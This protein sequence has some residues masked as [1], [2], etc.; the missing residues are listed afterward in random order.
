MATNY[1]GSLDTSTQQPSPSASTEMD[2][3]GFE[4]DVV[5]ANHSGAIIALETKVGTGD[6]NA[7]A[8]SVLAGTGSGTSAWTTAPTL[9]GLTVDTDTLHVD[10]TNNRVGIG[11]TTPAEPLHIVTAS[12]DAY[13]RQENGTATTYLGPDSANTG[14]FGTSTAHDVRFI[15][16]NT[17]RVRIDSSGNVGIGESSPETPLHIVTANRLGSTF[18]GTVD[19]E[20]L[21]VDQ[22][23]YSSGNYVSLVEASYD[24][25]QTVPHVRI[26]AMF[27]GG[28]SHLAFGTSNS[29]GSGIT[30]TA[31]FI[32][33]D[34]DVG[35]NTTSPGQRFHVNSGN[36]N[37]TSVFESGD[38][39][40]Y[41]GIKDSASSSNI[42]VAVGAVG[43]DMRLRAGNINRVAII[44]SN[45]RVGINTTSPSTTLDVNGSLSKASGSFKIPHP[46]P[47]KADTHDLV[48]SFVEA[49][50][51]DNLYRGRV[52]LTSGAATVDL[53]AAANMT[54]GTFPLLN[55]DVQCFIV[56]ADG[57]TFV[58]GSVSGSTLSIEAQDASCTDTVDWLVIGERHDQHMFD[59]EWTDDEGRVIV[60]PL[61][62]PAPEPDPEPDPEPEPEAA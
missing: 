30:N 56:N 37:T 47:A 19:G 46:L 22:S 32:A 33:E 53:D 39:T 43:N 25:G 61:R 51:A 12:D 58:R 42:H 48:H 10:A 9:S 34:G 16:G 8:S 29:F 2:D 27:D 6:S 17:E 50:Q 57:W 18:T 60:E 14:L 20:G 62:P 24:D 40:A 36:T 15:T 35:I 59:T 5:H 23:D 7:V 3:S 26:G 21:R 13:L 54:T 52:A 41:I 31:L 1:P 4:H 55:R 28:G 11:T 49:P 38:G 45:G 44:G